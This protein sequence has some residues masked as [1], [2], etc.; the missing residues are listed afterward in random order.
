MV[1]FFFT[2]A[3]SFFIEG[4]AER[5]F[6]TGDGSVH[7][8]GAP[9][10][11]ERRESA[12]PTLGRWR[13]YIVDRAGVC[14][15]S[16]S[17][18]SSGSRPRLFLRGT[19]QRQ[20]DTGVW[21]DFFGAR[22]VGIDNRKYRRLAVHPLR[23]ARLRVRDPRVAD[24][25]LHVQLGR[26]TQPHRIHRRRLRRIP[27]ARQGGRR[28]PRHRHPG[29]AARRLRVRQLRRHDPVRVARRSSPSSGRAQWASTSFP[30]SP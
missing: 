8:A 20:G 13:P 3:L 5:L 14:W 21:R 28:R 26:G 30:S 6:V 18:R 7:L 27:E 4:I 11:M 29:G 1:T 24:H 15:S 25:R 23:S 22:I 12:Q 17:R 16:H 9:Q 10:V 2:F 19:L